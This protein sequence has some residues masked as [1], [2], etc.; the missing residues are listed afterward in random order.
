MQRVKNL[1]TATQVAAEARVPLTWHRGLKDP[2][3]LQLQ[4][5]LQLWLGF[6][7]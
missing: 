4:R 5:R 1:T 7:P 6:S 3:M 2:V